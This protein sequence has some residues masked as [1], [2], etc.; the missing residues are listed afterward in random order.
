MCVSSVSIPSVCCTAMSI[1]R[2]R[3]VCVSIRMPTEEE[4]DCGDGQRKRKQAAQHMQ[5]D[6]SK[7]RAEGERPAAGAMAQHAALCWPLEGQLSLM[8]RWPSVR[9]LTACCSEAT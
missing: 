6:T 3:D 5:T 2:I 1:L 9:T 7:P 8:A 4:E